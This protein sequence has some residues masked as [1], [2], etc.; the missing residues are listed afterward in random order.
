MAYSHARLRK[1]LALV[2]I[3]TGVLF[4]VMGEYKVSSLE[5]ARVGFPQF[6]YDAMHGRGVSFYGSLLADIAGSRPGTFAIIVGLVELFIGVGLVLGLAVRPISLI[7]M[8]YM[9]NLMLATWMTPGP[10]ALLWQYL[11]GESVYIF[12][13]F[14]FLLLGVGHAGENWGLGAIYHGRRH[15]KW[16]N[17]G[18][19]E[20]TP[21]RSAVNRFAPSVHYPFE[22]EEREEEFPEAESPAR[23]AG[24]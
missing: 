19:S 7:G 10:D 23:R 1:T 17:P 9:A 18:A 24:Y 8:F 21:E 20:E 2:R 6:L 11:Q 3:V 22:E 12:G 5:F 13:F 15:V 14:L 4:L 16:E